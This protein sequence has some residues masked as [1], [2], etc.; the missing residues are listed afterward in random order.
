MNKRFNIIQLF[1]WSFCGGMWFLDSVVNMK[2][3]NFT[4]AGW[5]LVGFSVMCI[6]ILYHFKIAL[7]NV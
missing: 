3:G 6:V 1:M 4:D 5:K 2:A 7:K